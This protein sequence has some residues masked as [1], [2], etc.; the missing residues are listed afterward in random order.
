MSVGECVWEGMICVCVCVG[1]D[2]VCDGENVQQRRG[3]FSY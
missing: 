1:E 3:R 2:D